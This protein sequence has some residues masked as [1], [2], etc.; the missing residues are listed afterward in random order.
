MIHMKHVAEFRSLSLK[1]DTR[2]KF[3]RLFVEGCCRFA[4]GP[5][6]QP[7]RRATSHLPIEFVLIVLIPN[8]MS[9]DWKQAI[10]RKIN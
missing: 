6:R 5:D 9:T 10:V 2:E 1:P 7:P 4:T 3:H 8:Q